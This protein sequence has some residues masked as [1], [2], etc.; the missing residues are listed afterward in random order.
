LLEESIRNVKSIDRLIENDL[1]EPFN[2]Y[3]PASTNFVN[4][5]EG[6]FFPEMVKILR[7]IEEVE[8]IYDARCRG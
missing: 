8:N 3:V 1:Q 6:I 5:K 2:A 4:Y 7:A